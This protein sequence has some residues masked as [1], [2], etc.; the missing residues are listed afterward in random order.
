MPLDFSTLPDQQH[1]HANGDRAKTVWFDV[2]NGPVTPPAQTFTGYLSAGQSVILP[3][4]WFEYAG[5]TIKA[6]LSA[7]ASADFELRLE[8]WTNSA[9]RKVAECTSPTSSESV[10][11]PAS[12]GYYRVTVYSYSG[13][14]N[15]A[16]SMT[17]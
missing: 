7:P 8:R 12:A 9:W 11:Y 14:G 5:G 15:Y 1:G 3:S 17:K 4:P 2:G 13:A 16:L 10:T 6:T